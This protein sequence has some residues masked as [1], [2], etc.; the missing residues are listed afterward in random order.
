MTEVAGWQEAVAKAGK[1]VNQK[2]VEEGRLCGRSAEAHT[3][4]AAPWRR[5]WCGWEEE[6]EDR[7][8]LFRSISTGQ[9]RPEPN[10][11]VAKTVTPL[12]TT[13]HVPFVSTTLQ[14]LLPRAPVSI[15]GVP[16][17]GHC[18]RTGLVRGWRRV[19]TTSRRSD[20]APVAERVHVFVLLI[21]LETYRSVK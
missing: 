4:R 9:D 20:M 21:T 14:S 7:A 5:C 11:S 10:P 2:R 13:R 15:D 8:T 6:V 16:W 18:R 19:Q 1:A 3:V 12:G 17:L